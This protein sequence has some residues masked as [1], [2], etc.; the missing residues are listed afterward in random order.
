M[1]GLVS[2]MNLEFFNILKIDTPR[3][4]NVYINTSRV[5]MNVDSLHVKL[6]YADNCMYYFVL[7]LALLH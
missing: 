1:G 7:P 5:C 2:L 6:I 4:N 3:L